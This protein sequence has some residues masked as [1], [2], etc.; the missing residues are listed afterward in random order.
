MFNIGPMELLVILVLALIVVGPAKLPEVGRAI[1][2]ALR[3]FRKAQDEVRQTLTF[4]L[5]EPEPPRRSVRSSARPAAPE[6]RPAR[7]EEVPADH[8]VE[9]RL[10]AIRD[11]RPAAGGDGGAGDGGTADGAAADPSAAPGEPPA[12]SAPGE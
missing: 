9:D 5:E 11:D 4:D 3:E 2:R 8:Q 7:S 12:A 1:G 10:R 6:G